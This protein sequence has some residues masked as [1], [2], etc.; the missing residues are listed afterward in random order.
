MKVELAIK[1]ELKRDNIAADWIRPHF[2][3]EFRLGAIM[4]AAI[5]IFIRIA[6]GIEFLGMDVSSG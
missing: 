5:L 3:M 1:S 2:R 4:L 6:S